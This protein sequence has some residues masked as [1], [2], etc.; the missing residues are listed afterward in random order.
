[1]KKLMFVFGTRP[2]LIKIYPVIM[3]AQKRKLD[4]TIVNTGQHKQMVEGL[5]KKLNVKV[6]YNLEI[7]DKCTCLSEITAHSILGL[8][9]ILKNETPDVIFVHGDT[10]ATLSASLVGYYHQIKVAHIE[11]G[12]RTHNKYSPFPEEINRKITGVI[13]DFH[14]APTENSKRNL[15]NE[16]IL[17]NIFVVGNSAIDMFKYTLNSEFS[18]ELFN[19]EKIILVTI[20]RRENLSVLKEI[21]KAI[22]DLANKYTDYKFI[23]PIHLNPI[24]RKMAD[25]L[26][27][28][29]NIHIIEPVDVFDFHNFLMKSCM[30]ITDSGGIQEE[31]PSLGK[32]VIVVRNDT[33][34]PEGV[35][36]GTLKLV[37]TSKENIIKE[38][39]KILDSKELYD[40]MANIANPYG[41]G[42][43]SKYI[44]D[45]IEEN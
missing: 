39:S 8:E 45:I 6:D 17:G 2:E 26:L 16:G 27:N 10:S 12:L 43:T 30:I 44:L 37:G 36:A 7:M 9:K 1:M 13:A 23:Y 35:E 15:N 38:T 41:D 34:R 3:E 32:P 4:V 14:F 5:I 33:E 21:F 22:S 24:I 31:A 42:N 40:A 28:H 20:H 19:K 11:A 29:E 25:E 18:H